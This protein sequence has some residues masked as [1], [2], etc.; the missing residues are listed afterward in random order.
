MADCMTSKERLSAAISGGVPDYAPCCFMIFHALRGRCRNH[1]EFVRRQLDMGLDT[2]V[3]IPDLPIR[4]T[5]GVDIEEGREK[6]K[7]TGGTILRR[8]YLTPSGELTATV[9]KTEDWPHGD[10]VPLLDDYL[11][12]RSEKFLVAGPEDLPALRHLFAE[13]TA[14]D[15]AD[16]R[17]QSEKAHALADKL[18]LILAADWRSEGSP[19]FIVGSDPGRMG[20]DAL[21]WLCGATQPLFWALEEPDFL[22]ELLG[23][24]ASWNMRRMEVALENRPDLIVRRAWYEGTD[25]WSPALYAQFMLPILKREAALA[26]QAGARY[27]YILTSGVMPLLDMI[28]EAGV[29]VLIGTDPIQGKATNLAAMKSKCAGRMC[30]WGGV[31]GF[32]T[33]EMGSREQTRQATRDAMSAL[34]PGGGFILSPVDNI[35]EDSPRS[36][37][38]VAAMIEAWRE[39]R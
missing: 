24:I 9:R 15:I 10:H 18:Q 35:R 22:K 36:R 27:G 1:A 29:D 19:E 3:E 16:Y 20:V 7:T 26:H 23:I 31:N 38:N 30:L 14:E 4:F 5:P 28:I 34:A 8:K 2:R 33:V 12:P 11:A 17:S 25:F 37:E 32:L 21:M 39:C 6:D 13:P